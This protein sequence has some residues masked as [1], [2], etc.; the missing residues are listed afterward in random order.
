MTMRLGTIAFLSTLAITL[1]AGWSTLTAD[2]PEEGALERPPVATMVAGDVSVSMT[3][4]HAVVRP[5]ETVAVTLVASSSSRRDAEVMVS[6]LD[7]RSSE[8]SRM[9]SPPR[10]VESETMKLVAMP[11]G[12][13]ART[14]SFTLAAP[15]NEVFDSD[16]NPTTDPI[17]AA[18]QVAQYTI[19]VAPVSKEKAKRANADEEM[20]GWMPE[21]AA[22]IPVQVKVP[23][24]YNLEVIAVKAEAD[25]KYVASVRVTNAAKKTLRNIN[26]SLN[27]SAISFEALE[28]SATIETLA[29]GASV[30]VKFKGEA[31]GEVDATTD[32]SAYGYAEYGGSAQLATKVAAK[33]AKKTA[34]IAFATPPPALD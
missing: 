3:L 20:G 28:D 8:M 2:G 30:V 16:G 9:P 25:G 32:L 29:A 26:V 15:S 31:Y 18:G 27:S 34:P 21:N 5:G 6:V 11:G 10:V 24:A 4:D 19:V 13:K 1:P 22:A 17:Y 23:Q 12:G 14:L 33:A 7:E